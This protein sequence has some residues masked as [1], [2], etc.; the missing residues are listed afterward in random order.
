MHKNSKKKLLVIMS[1]MIWGFIGYVPKSA[2]A[3]SPGEPKKSEIIPSQVSKVASDLLNK[4]PETENLSTAIA[5][6]NQPL[7]SKAPE[8]FNVAYFGSKHGSIDWE[9]F[10]LPLWAQSESIQESEQTS[11]DLKISQGTDTKSQQTRSASPKR[12]SLGG[13]S[14]VD[15]QLREDEP[16]T[17]PLIRIPAIDNLLQPYFDWKKR[18][19]EQTGLSLGLDYNLLYQTADSSLTDNSDAA[20]GVFRVFGEWDLVNRDTPNT[21]S[22]VFKFEDRHQIGDGVPPSGLGFDLGYFGVTGTSFSGGVTNLTVLNWQQR[23]NNGKAGFLV[24]RFF[25]DDYADVSGY[26]NPWTTFQNASIL[27]N[28]TI[29]YPDQGFGFGGGGFIGEQIYLLGLASD[30]NG[31]LDEFKFFPGG[32]EFFKY[33]EVGWTPSPEERYLRNIHLGGWHTDERDDAGIDASYGITFSANWTLNNTR[34]MPFFRAGWSEGDAPLANAAIAT[35]VI[36]KVANLSDLAGLGFNWS[37]PPDSSLEDQYA[38]ELFYRLQLATNLAIT[39]SF[40]FIINPALDPDED[41]IAVFGF[42]TRL[43][44]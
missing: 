8:K 1:G 20:G 10:S 4:T 19:Q 40:Q 25:P 37:S 38:T 9:I 6:D 3:Q 17:K 32:A 23:L 28:A 29:A 11:L 43:N 26:A 14:S 39:P 2:L 33:A 30:A 18:V 42:R 41:A 13:P 16:P 36:Y 35:G 44:L 12:N 7:F 34:W 5:K 15:G 21:G 22:L 24:G 27:V 31:K